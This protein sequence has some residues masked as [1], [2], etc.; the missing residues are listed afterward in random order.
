MVSLF[1][2]L[3]RWLQLPG[4]KKTLLDGAP[5]CGDLPKWTPPSLGGCWVFCAEE[6]TA[7]RRGRAREPGTAGNNTGPKKQNRKEKNCGRTREGRKERNA[8]GAKSREAPRD[9]EKEQPCECEGP[10]SCI[11]LNTQESNALAGKIC[12]Y[13]FLCVS[14]IPLYIQ[15]LTSAQASRASSSS[16][17]AHTKFPFAPCLCTRFCSVTVNPRNWLWGN[18]QITTERPGDSS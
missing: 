16:N 3:M 11:C 17:T 8:R 6:S 10:S 2:P 15:T 4:L 1:S 12:I 18:L 13:I 14:A 5:G 9:S 7:S